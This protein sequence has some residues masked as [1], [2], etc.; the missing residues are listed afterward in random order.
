[1]SVKCTSKDCKLKDKCER[2]LYPSNGAVYH[3]HEDA[4]KTC[5]KP[6]KD[7]ENEQK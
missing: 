7:V 5:F 3:Y 1:M 6:R 4:E 2:P